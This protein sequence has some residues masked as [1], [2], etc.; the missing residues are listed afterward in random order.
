[1]SSES[2]PTLETAEYNKLLDTLLYNAGTPKPASVLAA[3][4]SRNS[5]TL[6]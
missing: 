6:S 3:C 5:R 2:L 1:M 4:G